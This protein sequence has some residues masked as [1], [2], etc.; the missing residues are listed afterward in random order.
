[1]LV[2]R[3]H[4]GNVIYCV[5]HNPGSTLL[6]ITS[7]P[8]ESPPTLK[9]ER[10]EHFTRMNMDYSCALCNR[11]F[12]SK[13]ALEQ[14][15]RDSPVHNTTAPAVP[16]AINKA[17]ASQKTAA[18]KAIPK[19]ATPTNTFHCETCDQRFGSKG[20]LKQHKRDSPVHKKAFRC[21]TC[22]QCFGSKGALEQHDRDSPVHRITF[23]CET[24]DQHFGSKQALEDHARSCRVDQAFPQHPLNASLGQRRDEAVPRNTQA[25]PRILDIPSLIIKRHARKLES[26]NPATITALQKILGENTPESTQETREFFLFP[27]LHQSIAEAVFPEILSTWFQEDDD[28]DDCDEEWQTHVMGIFIC[29]NNACKAQLW[30]SRMVPIEIRG[31]DSNGYSATVYNER[32]MSCNRLGTFVLDEDSYIGRV[33]YRLKKWAGVAV[34]KPY[35]GPKTGLDHQREFC[36]GC[37]R[38]K[39]RDMDRYVL[40]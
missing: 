3:L 29:T 38:G 40:Y 22:N 12:G 35:Y 39:C 34:E 36:E 2:T 7:H 16:E 14:H 30:V 26:V 20:A 5:F 21:E 33:A 15:E 4:K 10:A 37:R 19:K 24:C 13:E 8:F 17:V 25:S 32:C 11:N 28:D 9:T 6:L 31:Y 1:M 27:E 18:K 23:H